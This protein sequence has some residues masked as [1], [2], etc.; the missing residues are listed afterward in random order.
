[1]DFF[2]EVYDLYRRSGIEPAM[3]RFRQRTFPASDQQVMS[4]APRNEANA[5]YWFEH[6]L[7][8]YPAVDLDLNALTA[9]ADRIVPAVGREGAG[10]PAHDV[11][12]ELAKKLGRDMLELP[13]GHVGCLAHPAEFAR[14]LARGTQTAPSSM[15]PREWDES[16]ASPPHWDTGRPQPAFRTL[17]DG[18]AIQG[19]VLDVSCGTGEHVLMAAALGLDAT[20]ADFASAPLRIAEKR[21]TSGASAHGSSSKTPGS[22]PIWVSRS[23]RFSPAACSTSSTTRTAPPTWPAYGRRCDRVDAIS[24]CASATSSPETEDLGE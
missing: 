9:H 8:Q 23:T 19:R 24:C 1:M 5:A 7:R 13:G 16:Y 17:A 20:G 6:E 15:S 4:H 22:W 2:T 18:D 12:I 14:E 10:Y 3:K 21:H 11:T